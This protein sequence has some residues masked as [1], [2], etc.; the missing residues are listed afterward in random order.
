MP[1]SSSRSYFLAD[2]SPQDKTDDQM[3]TDEKENE[4]QVAE[5]ENGQQ[6]YT[7]ILI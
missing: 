7:L 2:V 1:I 5:Y 4:D 3:E 6:T